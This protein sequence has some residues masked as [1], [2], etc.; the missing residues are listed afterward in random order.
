MPSELEAVEPGPD[1]VLAGGRARLER[2]LRARL[3]EG[4]PLSVTF[5]D[6][7]EAGATPTGVGA[8][9]I[10]LDAWSVLVGPVGSAPEPHPTP[11]PQCL[12]LRW[13][14]LRP[15]PEQEAVGPGRWQD[16]TG[17]SP[18]LH[19]FALDA[20]W[21][22]L[23]RVDA[24]G[25]PRVYEL[26]LE[27]LRVR[28]FPLVADPACQACARLRPDTADG[29]RL[30]FATRTK[31][32]VGQ[33]RLLRAADYRLPVR[34]FVNPVCGVLGSSTGADMFSAT[35]APV[36]G[37][38]T[39]HTGH[40]FFDFSWGG[41]ADSYADSEVLAIFEGLERYAGLHRR[42]VAGVTVDSYQNLRALALDPRGCGVYDD[43][44]YRT[45]P[46]LTTFTVDRAIPWVWGY[47]LRDD[48]PVL[49][50]EQ[51]AYYLGRAGGDKFVHE[52]SNGCATGS[53]L[54]E[55]VLHGML[56]LIE[57]DAFLLAWYGRADLPEIDPSTCRSP[58]R[59][60]LDRLR[61]CG[62]D[63]R[64]FD[65]RVDLRVPVVTAVAIRRD[66]GL[67]RL[68]FAAGASF[69]PEE[70]VRGALSE[71][72]SYISSL[73]QRVAARLGEV[74]AMARDYTLVTEL[75]DHAL[76]FGLPEM[77]AHADFMLAERPTRTMAELYQDWDRERPR[78]LDLLDDLRYCRDILVD[79]GHDVI[80]V[81]Q[82]SPEQELVG[83]RSA[84]VIVP[85]AIPIDFGWTKQR[86]LRMP[87]MRTAYRRAGWRTTDLDDAE[88]NRVPHPFP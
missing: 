34:A 17:P 40:A 74:Q 46:A 75:A 82:T 36:T 48:R 49:V 8:P 35:T 27:S 55:A 16:A 83:L 61:L 85:G 26:D 45:D 30:R 76:L 7:R 47:S 66:D 25:E 19:R 53:C 72:A 68:C 73:P 23:G 81:D 20:L 88:L 2:F 10:Q 21:Q 15:R 9:A 64:L 69:D 58:T 60:M 84:R 65:T 67:G 43:A 29:A 59:F 52:C 31:P 28:S 6:P 78:T 37:R 13:R 41:H 57:R 44:A 39:L 18:F 1:P 62:Y 4:T 51:S 11:C 24:S 71:T 5:L 54:E 50:A 79:A 86:A 56:E 87:R 80:V 38:S 33:Y 12:S 77:A 22:L 14:R 42:A 63:V 70:A 3:P 32:A